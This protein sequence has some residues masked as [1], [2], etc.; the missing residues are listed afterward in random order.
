[1]TALEEIRSEIEE[2]KKYRKL[3]CM[4]EKEESLSEK[5]ET[6]ENAKD[7]PKVKRLEVRRNEHI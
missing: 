3:L 5:K 6:Q 7:K 1:M 2:L 4:L